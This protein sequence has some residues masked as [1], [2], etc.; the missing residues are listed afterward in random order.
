MLKLS[1]KRRFIQNSTS[2]LKFVNLEQNQKSMKTKNILITFCCIVF[3]T[4]CDVSNQNTKGTPEQLGI[5]SE[6]LER[7][8]AYLN[9]AI[10]DSIIP[11][12]VALVARNGTVV[13]KKA[14]G[15]ENPETQTA[16]QTDHIFRI[17]SMS[18]A[19]TSLGVLMLWEEGKF[20]LDDPIE[21]YIPEFEGVGVLDTFNPADSTFTTK[22]VETKITIRHLL[23]HTSGLGYGV[24]DGD[25]RFKAIYHKAGIVELFTT[26]E[27]SIEENIKKLATLPLHHEPGKQFTYSEGL[28]VLG[29]FI[30]L[31]SGQKFDTFLETRIFEPLDMQDTYF[32]LPETHHERLVHIQTKKEG[33][34]ELFKGA[35][36][37]EDYPMKGAQTFFS[38]GAGLSSTVEDY[39][40]FLQ[41][42]LDGGKANGTQFI[43]KKT[44]EL[45]FSDQLKNGSD[46]EYGLAF[47]ILS[48]N[49]YDKGGAGSVGT[50]TWGGYF[51]TSYF[52]DPKENVVGLIYKQTQNIGNDPTSTAFRELVFQSIIK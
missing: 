3:L 24:I 15:I 23:T 2:S 43:G 46:F 17:A 40:K 16:F 47:G 4:S 52:A 9:Q 44:S 42:F 41:L 8:D 5:D 50:L 49:Q 20:F 37:D 38:G 29:Y 22:A 26:E 10:K 11:G 39:A 45:I 13:Y 48:K 18:K 51:N 33:Q 35:F 25:P 27:V 12:A 6:R 30:E 21:K 32:Y 19:I 28:D 7:I 31:M 34:W 14:F 36:Y 1:S